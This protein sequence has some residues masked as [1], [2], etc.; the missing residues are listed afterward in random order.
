MPIPEKDRIKLKLSRDHCLLVPDTPDFRF[1]FAQKIDLSDEIQ[2][3]SLQPKFG[4]VF[5]H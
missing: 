5:L 3:N 2:G 4:E 1:I